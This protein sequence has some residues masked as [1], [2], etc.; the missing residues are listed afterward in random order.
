[1]VQISCCKKAETV[2]ELLSIEVVL[3]SLAKF[4]SKGCL[5]F[6]AIITAAYRPRWS[7]FNNQ[8]HRPLHFFNLFRCLL[9][10]LKLHPLKLS[11]LI[12]CNNF[13]GLGYSEYH[14]FLIKLKRTLG[15]IYILKYGLS[16]LNTWHD[17]FQNIK[18]KF[19]NFIDFH[20]QL[21]NS[22]SHV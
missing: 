6:L 13:L 7:A 21:Y 16:H 15:F 4:H 3:I 19:L 1:M 11:M 17:I 18:I 8:K 12:L 9:V 2:S 20:Q 5:A 14:N 10:P 22:K